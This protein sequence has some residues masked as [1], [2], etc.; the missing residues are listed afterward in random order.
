MHPRLFASLLNAVE[1]WTA[2][3]CESDEWTSD[4]PHWPDN[5]DLNMATAAAL[6][7][8]TIVETTREAEENFVP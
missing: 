2:S 6:V 1:K 3:E 5:G 7:Y 4:S 8:D